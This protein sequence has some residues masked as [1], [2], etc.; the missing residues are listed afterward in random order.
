MSTTRP[1]CES[2]TC[3]TTRRGWFRRRARERTPWGFLTTADV[4]A[5]TRE[6]EAQR[7][8]CKVAPGE[9]V[10]NGQ[11][12][13][14]VFILSP[15]AVLPGHEIHDRSPLSQ[16]ARGGDG[17]DYVPV[18]MS[19]LRDH[20]IQLGRDR[21]G[22]HPNPGEKC[23]EQP[24]LRVG[25]GRPRISVQ[26]S[27]RLRPCRPHRAYLLIGTIGDRRVPT[28][29]RDACGRGSVR[30]SPFPRFCLSVRSSAAASSHE[31][32]VRRRRAIGHAP[33]GPLR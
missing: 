2:T 32:V 25:G 30:P 19:V 10:C 31:S 14:Q 15:A 24:R 8:G 26:P 13:S 22:D 18:V 5:G 16:G 4:L 27:R 3:H 33:V 29:L 11:G 9:T 20:T 6:N 1:P 23:G 28:L 21:S 7:H 12:E 17:E